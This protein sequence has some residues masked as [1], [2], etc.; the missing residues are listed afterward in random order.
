MRRT[1]RKEPTETVH[2]FTSRAD[3]IARR[4]HA[5]RVLMESVNEIGAPGATRF[6]ASVA[7]Q[8]DAYLDAHPA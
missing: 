8:A 6:W 2:T 7:R 1:R 4:D 5:D 3:A